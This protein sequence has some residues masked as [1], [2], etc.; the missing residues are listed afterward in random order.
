LK[1]ILILLP[2]FFPRI[3]LY[4]CLPCPREVVSRLGCL[5]SL[6]LEKRKLEER[7]QPCDPNSSEAQAAMHAAAQEFSGPRK[8]DFGG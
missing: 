6:K 5:D 3:S 2:C 8:V 4:F 1:K 7:C